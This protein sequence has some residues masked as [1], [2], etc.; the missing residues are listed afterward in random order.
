MGKIE[1]I[2]RMLAIV[3]CVLSIYI[4]CKSVNDWVDL[5]HGV[6]MAGWIYLLSQQIRHLINE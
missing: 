1:I 2:L 6:G 5:L 4:I 3:V